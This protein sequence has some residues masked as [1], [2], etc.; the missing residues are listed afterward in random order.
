M[1]KKFGQIV[2]TFEV[3]PTFVFDHGVFSTIKI[4]KK[5]GKSGLLAKKWAKSGH[6]KRAFFLHKMVFF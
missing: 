1:E 4:E 2:A 3:V 6:E 5:V